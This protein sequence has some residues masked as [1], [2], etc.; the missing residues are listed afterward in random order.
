MEKYAPGRY[1]RAVMSVITTLFCFISLMFPRQGKRKYYQ[2]DVPVFIKLKSVF[3]LLSDF[4]S[5]HFSCVFMVLIVFL[6]RQLEK[7]LRR[8]RSTF[9]SSSL[10]RFDILCLSDKLEK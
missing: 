9:R 6:I 5:C 2:I 4:L 8:E 1:V 7:T 3:L 10:I